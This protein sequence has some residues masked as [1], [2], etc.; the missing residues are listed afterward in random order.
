MQYVITATNKRKLIE[1]LIDLVTLEQVIFRVLIWVVCLANDVKRRSTGQHLKHQDTQRPPIN[2]KIFQKEKVSYE[3][4]PVIKRGSHLNRSQ[5][6]IMYTGKTLNRNWTYQSYQYNAY[7]KA[8]LP[9]EVNNSCKNSLRSIIITEP[10]LMLI[11]IWNTK[12]PAIHKWFKFLV[13]GNLNFYE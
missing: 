13:D 4:P 11:I 7:E 1:W 3:K 10:V 8:K 6:K 5:E 9:I 2:A 12:A